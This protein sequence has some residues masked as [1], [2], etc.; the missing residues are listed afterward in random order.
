MFEELKIYDKI[1]KDHPE[2]IVIHDDPSR[3]MSIN[4]DLLPE[5]IHRVYLGRKDKNIPMIYSKRLLERAKEIHCVDSSFLWFVGM[6][7]IK[8]KKVLHSYARGNLKDDPEV[9][10]W[11]DEGPTWDVI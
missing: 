5:G 4:D 9:Y 3:N 10:F 6:N 11:R 1:A 7:R 2:Y 8:T